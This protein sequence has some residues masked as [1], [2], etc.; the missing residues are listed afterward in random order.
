MCHDIVHFINGKRAKAKMF[1]GF[2]CFHCQGRLAIGANGFCS[3]CLKLLVKTPYCGR[4]GAGLLEDSLGCGNCVRDEPKW[5]RLVQVSAYKSPLVE[6]IHRFKF[7]HQHPLDNALARQLLLAIY[8]AK[9]Q[10]GLAL[11]EVILPVP[12][13]WKRQWR[14]GFNQAELI[15]KPIS[16]WLNIPLDNQS[17]QRIRETT[18]QRN[19]TAVQRRQNLKGAFVYQPIT[20]YQRVAI[21]D[22]V[23][24]TG[25]TINAICVE[26]LRQKVKEIQVWTLARA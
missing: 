9:R 21:V 25:S 20:P 24:T 6:W 2:R 11:P 7:Q 18:S 3:R 23:V 5:H 12:L 10:H 4:C 16:K 22:D 15:A 14:R 1:W 8:Q 19:F 17:L 26:L 13:F